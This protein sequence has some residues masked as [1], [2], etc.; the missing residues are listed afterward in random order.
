M[1]LEGNSSL[2]EEVGTSS[3]KSCL[4]ERRAEVGRAEG[5][6]RHLA[7][8]EKAQEPSNSYQGLEWPGVICF[9]VLS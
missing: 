3:S 6:S 9:N 8:V 5:I 2:V 7:V 1:E 4:N